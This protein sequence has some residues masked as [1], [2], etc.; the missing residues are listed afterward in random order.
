M[1]DVEID[2]TRRSLITEIAY[3]HRFG[4]AS[5]LGAGFQNTLSH[6]R[7]KYIGT[8]YRPILTE[9]NNYG[10]VNYSFTI[11][12]FNFWLASGVKIFRMENGENKRDFVRNLSNVNINWILAT[13]GV[14]RPTSIIRRVSPACPHSPTTSSR[15]RPI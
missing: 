8:D 2:N 10:Y 12:K 15:P 5:E 4:N 9:N 11:D 3:R 6:S 14:C 13:N 7:N 1:Y